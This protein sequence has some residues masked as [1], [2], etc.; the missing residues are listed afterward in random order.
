MMTIISMTTGILLF[1]VYRLQPSSC[2]TMKTLIAQYVVHKLIYVI[3]SIVHLSFKWQ[4]KN[5]KR[6]QEDL[7][8]RVIKQN[9]NTK[10]AQKLGIDKTKSVSQFLSKVPLTS[11]EDYKHLVN[12]VETLGVENVFFPG[13]V[14]YLAATSGTTSGKS[15]I[16]PKNWGLFRKHTGPWFL[17]QQKCLLQLPGN[18]L[19]RKTIA[20]RAYPKFYHSKSGIKSGP[21]YGIAADNSLMFYVVPKRCG[22]IS[23]EE[24][25]IYIN[26]VFGLL[27]EKIGNLFFSTSTL[28]LTFFKTLEKKWK[29]IC[30][31]I[32]HGTIS[33]LVEVPC[34]LRDIFLQ[35]LNGG[36][37]ER[38][39]LLRKEFQRGFE[40]LVPR[41]WPECH[42]IFCISTGTFQTAAKILKDKYLGDVPIFSL[43]HVSTETAYGLN[44]DLKNDD[45]SY[46]ALTSLNFFEFIPEGE[47]E[48]DMPKTILANQVSV[49]LHYLFI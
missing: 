28:A 19:L 22:K 45:H 36:N 42:A 32:Q 44:F 20:V 49:I 17:M 18:N 25:V 40:A 30:E 9:R 5:C 14:N 16:F 31:D 38:A 23:N 43:Y 39:D 4:T 8:M 35:S 27:E 3:G 1:D 21:I 34:D 7:L 29:C 12:E 13:K 26:L 46:V 41:I 6:Q 47:I 15:K 2:H 33:N 24:D 11:Y 48:N 10:C 37:S